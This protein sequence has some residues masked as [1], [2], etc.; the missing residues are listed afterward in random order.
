MSRNTMNRIEFLK[1]ADKLREIAGDSTELRQSSAE[2]LPILQNLIETP[3]N[4]KTVVRTAHDLGLRLKH[5][6]HNGGET[7]D[8][9]AQLTRI[10]IKIDKLLRALE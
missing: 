1:V 9:A 5:M 10:E 3:I 6:A 2:L 8:I 7:P 4:E